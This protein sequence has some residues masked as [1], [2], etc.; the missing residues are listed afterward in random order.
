[1][2]REGGCLELLG[3]LQAFNKFVNGN[4]DSDVLVLI[5]LRTVS[6]SG[7]SAAVDKFLRYF[8]E[9]SRKFLESFL[10]E[11]PVGDLMLH[12]HAIT[13]GDDRTLTRLLL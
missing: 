9:I 12:S 8:L 3:L 10:F 7:S 1:M 11:F 2:G 4:A 6:G 13:K 5:G